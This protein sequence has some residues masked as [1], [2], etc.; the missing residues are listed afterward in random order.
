[1][2]TL[3]N[4]DIGYLNRFLEF[5]GM[6]PISWYAEKGV[7]PPIILIAMFIKDAGR[8]SIYFYSALLCIDTELFDAANIDGA[9][10]IKQIRHISLPAMSK[11][12]CITLISSL[13]NVLDSSISPFYQLTF[14]RGVLYDTTLTL[15][16]Y[17]KNGLGNGRYAFTTAV[18]LTQSIVGLIFVLIAN[19]IVKRIDFES[20]IF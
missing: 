13:G 16:M 10:R 18:G 2:M 11:V 19:G 8:A 12:F 9:S 3:L 17:Q 15:G 14:D 4:P 20:A 1:M 6:E 5:I 7:W